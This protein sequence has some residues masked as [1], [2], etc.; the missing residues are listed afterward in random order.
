MKILLVSSECDPY[1]KV[2]GLGDVIPA[3][4]SEMRTLGHDVRIILPK[5][6]SI[7]FPLVP[8]GG[9][10]IVNM[11]YGIE[12]ARLWCAENTDVPTYFIEFNRY[13]GRSGVY[14]ENGH[15][16]Q[17]NGERFAFFDRAVL[18]ACDFLNWIPDIIHTNDWPTG[19][20]PAIIHSGRW[21]HHPKTVFTIH[22][23]A[24]HGIAPRSILSFLGLP[25]HYFHPFALESCGAINA[26]KGAL[27]FADK[28]TTVSHRY[29]E[30]IK[31]PAS[32]CGLDDVLRYRASDLKGI[33]NGIDLHLW[34]PQ[35]DPLLPFHYSVT[36]KSGKKLC[37][38]ALQTQTQLPLSPT[39]PLFGV[40]ARFF[41]QKGLDIL[42]NI[43]P[44]LLRNMSIQMV[45]LG[46]G[47][48]SLENR[49]RAIQSQFPH[50]FYTYIGYNEPL[51]HLIEAGCDFFVMPSRYE[52]CGLNQ[53]YSMHYGTLPIVHYTGG[54]ADTVDNYN[55]QT[56]EGTGFVLYD[57]NESALYNTIGWAC[58]TY[59]DRPTDIEVMQ[60]RGM[61]KDFSWTT[62]AQQYLEIYR[63]IL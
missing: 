39:T 28:I 34:N 53:M 10:M 45:V 35:S 8:M 63:S 23:M 2:G 52:P 40:I 32:G 22:N 24:H 25:E 31:T 7:S 47:D 16:F 42:C 60:T 14:G 37:K 50:Q 20:I 59:Y 5:Y 36:Q 38:E 57:L 26:M 33:C 62:S 17:D 46:S 43:L 27:Q 49:F 9:P 55:Q 58:S 15:S 19:L 12:F 6:N 54:L 56:K 21:S 3:L 18:D 13:F 41:S 1:V 4:A 44:D 48:H 29:A 61:N 30:E 11:G 51:A